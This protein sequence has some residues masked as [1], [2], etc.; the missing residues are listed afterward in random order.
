MPRV[1]PVP[2][3]ELPVELAT[4]IARG[5][6]TGV[7][8][9]S[10]PI[11]V[12]AHRPA[13]AAGWLNTLQALHDTA[14]LSPRERELVRLRISAITQCKACQLARKSDTVTEE[15]IA[16]L[17]STDARF[18][19]REQAALG[20]AEQFSADYHNIDD[21]HFSQLRDLFSEAEIVE[22]NLFCAL[23]L[24]GGRLTY[25]QQAYD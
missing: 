17:Q 14:L 3:P 1:T 8:S 2:A 15:D 5:L 11:E 4:A 12:W 10:L 25:V 20:F 21:T 18:S 24:A 19:P 22:L 16:C 23:M 7:L 13:V 6:D 9:T